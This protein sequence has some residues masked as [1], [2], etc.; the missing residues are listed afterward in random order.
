MR[1]GVGTMK[2]ANNNRF[3]GNWARDM[4]NGEGVHYFLDRGQVMF[5]VIQLAFQL[6]SVGATL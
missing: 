1:D 2:Y 6:P 5:C 3:E 4:K